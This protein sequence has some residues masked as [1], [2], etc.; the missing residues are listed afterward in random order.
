MMEDSEDQKMTA[1]KRAYADMIL[2]MAKESAARILESERRA[3]RLQHSL[4]LA[5]EEALATLL[6]LKSIMDLKIKETERANLGQVR[7]IQELEGQ[8]NEAK[9][10]IAYLRSELKIVKTELENKKNTQAKLLDEQSKDRDGTYEDSCQECKSNSHSL[11]CSKS[12]STNVPTSDTNCTALSQ[13]TV[14]GHYCCCTENAKKAEILKDLTALNKS[15]DRNDLASFILSSKEP[16]LFRNGC[17][18]RIRAF[19]QNLLTG[20]EQPGQSVDHLSI[21]KN[22]TTVCENGNAERP[23]TGDLAVA[24]KTVNQ[25]GNPFVSKEVTQQA[26]RLSSMK[27]RTR[28]KLVAKCASRGT[29]HEKA[30][31]EPYDVDYLRTLSSIKQRARGKLVKKSTSCGTSHGKSGHGSSDINC[32]K[33]VVENN[34]TKSYKTLHRAL[35]EAPQKTQSSCMAYLSTGNSKT[36]KD[37]EI[38]LSRLLNNEKPELLNGNSI[39]MTRRT[40]TKHNWHSVNQICKNLQSRSGHPGQEN[41]VR[42][43]PLL[44]TTNT[45]DDDTNDSLPT[46][47]SK[48][49]TTDH[50]VAVDLDVSMHEKKMIHGTGDALLE[51]PDLKCEKTCRSS[52]PAEAGSDR[53]L[54]T[55]QRKRKRES[56]V[57]KNE[58]VSVEKKIASKRIGD[59]QKA[60][61]EPQRPS[62]VVESS[63]DNRRVAQVARQ[64]I[65]LS[66]KRW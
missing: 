35:S 60:S 7:K 44:R 29:Y 17:T 52:G 41:N 53:I 36:S 2:N 61:L 63:R 4:S 15:A 57:S 12:G 6:R 33:I 40:V 18:Q 38:N 47:C 51:N 65:A 11:L 58:T 13:R 25:A 19:E 49:T 39:I 14:V 50:R 20:R 55:F 46:D 16:D 21:L 1:L 43:P 9:D 3:I 31:C 54:K 22:E 8:F 26:S 32:S 28:Q 23:K 5:K 37:R 24:A 10:T 42:E 30:D 64:L 27:R 66:R 62:L 34:L 56:P 48:L 59:K 45:I